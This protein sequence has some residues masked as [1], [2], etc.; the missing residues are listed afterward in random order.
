M[1]QKQ[2]KIEVQ[3]QMQRALSN[4]SNMFFWRNK[5]KLKS[6]YIQ[7]DLALK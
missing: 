7:L 5:T 4:S 6:L 1:K 3:W 2:A